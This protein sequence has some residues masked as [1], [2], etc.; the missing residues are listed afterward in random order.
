MI[1]EVI[2]ATALASSAYASG[3]LPVAH[4][5]NPAKHSGEYV[6]TV[7]RGGQSAQVEVK[8][9]GQEDVIAARLAGVAL[10]RGYPNHAPAAE[11][12][13]VV[14]QKAIERCGNDEDMV[15]MFV[16]DARVAYI[17]R[18]RALN[19]KTGLSIR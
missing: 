5:Y 10:T 4:E 17:T 14:R 3:S 18:M 1:K 13:A 2:A 16:N 19:A 15:R 6:A 8:V 7:T 9:F 12:E 11:M